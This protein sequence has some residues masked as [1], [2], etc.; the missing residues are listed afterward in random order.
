MTHSIHMASAVF[1]SA[2]VLFFATPQDSGTA[3][4]PAASQPAV[5]AANEE[6]M[7]SILKLS[8]KQVLQIRGSVAKEEDEDN[9]IGGAMMMMSGGEMGASAFE[10]SFDIYAAGGETILFS[11]ENGLGFGIYKNADRTITRETY[12]DQK[13]NIAVFRREALAFVDMANLQKRFA[14]AAW[15]KEPP[16]GELNVYTAK[17]DKKLIPAAK[18]AGMAPSMEKIVRI[19]TKISTNKAGEIIELQFSVVKKDPFAE[20][21]KRTK[22]D[23]DENG[24]GSA[25]IKID[26]ADLMN[27]NTKDTDSGNAT[28][29]KFGIV[30]GDMNPRIVAFQKAM[31][32][33]GEKK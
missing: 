24:A 23:Q 7:K 11:E 13:M 26:P 1:A 29:Y 3:S 28:T 18:G 2:L 32:A 25:S 33:L 9:P 8:E 10:G 22:I 31:Q 16:T 15:T 21:I 6:V 12:D 17:V 14:K 20:M 4:A 19:D 27:D 5:S 30:S